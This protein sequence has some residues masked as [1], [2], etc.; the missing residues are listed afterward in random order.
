LLKEESKEN[1]YNI[2]NDFEGI[3]EYLEEENFD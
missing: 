1:S 3:L 2:L